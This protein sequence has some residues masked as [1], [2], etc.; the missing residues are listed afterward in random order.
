MPKRTIFRSI[1]SRR[2]FLI[3]G[4]TALLYP[5]LRFISHR[6]PRKPVLIKVTDPLKQD[7]FLIKDTFFLF[8]QKDQVWAVSRTCTH[9]G[10]R[11]NYKEKENILEC[12]CHQSRFA[13]TGEV[14][15]GPA[16]R[17]LT[18]YDVEINADPPYFLVST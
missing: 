7:R 17:A 11:L 3:L 5:L 15:K 6:V 12:P 18:Q 13:I 10:C 14:L 4:S 2:L 16:Q 9:L 8:S 1:I